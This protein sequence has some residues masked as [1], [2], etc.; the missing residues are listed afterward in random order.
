MSSDLRDAAGRSASVDPA[1]FNVLVTDRMQELARGLGPELRPVVE[2]LIARPGKRVRSLLVAHS[3][4]LGTPNAH[5]T[6][7]V[8]A[9]VEYLQVASLLHDD[10]VDR[11][12]TRRSAPAAH[13]T[14]G[15]ELALLGG[16]ACFALAGTEAAELGPSAAVLTSRVASELARGQMLDVERCFDTE[17][18]FDDYVTLVAG[19]TSPLFRLAC[20]LGASTSCC[21]RPIVDALG[22]FATELGIAFQ[23]A[24]DC[25]DLRRTGTGKPFAQDLA[26]GLFGAPVLCALSSA[27]DRELAELLVSPDLSDA[28]LDRVLELVQHLEGV[29]QARAL[30]QEHRTAMEEALAELPDIPARA[31]LHAIADEVLGGP[32]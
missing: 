18:A 3:A 22:R 21:P 7:R 4:T 30:A 16:M 25:L 8:A 14:H 9:I 20:Q 23:I 13:V 31:A 19:K 27:N 32:A 10:V 2:G 11:A 6:A 24:D 5:R 26:L 28:Q 29:E 15:V 1:A 17:L 12:D